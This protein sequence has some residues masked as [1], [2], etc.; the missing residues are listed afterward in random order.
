MLHETIPVPIPKAARRSTT[1]QPFSLVRRGYDRRE[2]DDRVQ[3]MATQLGELRVAHRREGRRAAVA[4]E[5][6]HATLARVEQLTQSGEQGGSG[7]QGFG[8]RVEKLLRAAEHE[9]SEARSAA[10]SEATALLERARED[11]EAHRH[12]VEQALISRGSELDHRAAQRTVELDERQRQIGKHAASARDEAERALADA[13]RDAEQIRQQA[14]A[15][16]LA[17]RADTERAI[18]EQRAGAEQELCRLRVLR[19]E[20]R[21]Q[22]A[23]LLESLAPEFGTHPPEPS[24][25]QRHASYSPHQ[26]HPQPRP[27]PHSPAP[28]HIAEQ[29]TGAMNG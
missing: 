4:E 8:Y 2:V 24:R 13:H 7:Q 12:E 29:K 18:R 19:D 28:M 27:Y 11:A 22:L 1:A 17:D 6:L 25:L 26:P 23:T 5:Q 21:G 20:I 10:A 15:R 16:A 3:A 14:Q 9:A